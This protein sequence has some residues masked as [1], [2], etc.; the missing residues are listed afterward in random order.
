MKIGHATSIPTPETQ[1]IRSGKARAQFIRY[2]SA[3]QCGYQ[4]RD[5]NDTAEDGGGLSLALMAKTQILRNPKS[6][7]AQHECHSGLCNRS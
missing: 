2:D 7:P 5:A 3:E 1:K 4:A 6:E